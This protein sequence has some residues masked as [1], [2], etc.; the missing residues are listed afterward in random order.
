MSFAEFLIDNDEIMFSA[1]CVLFT[2]QIRRVM[3]VERVAVEEFRTTCFE[4]PGVQ[5]T[6]TLPAIPS[7]S[8]LL[9][10]VTAAGRTF[11]L[12]GLCAFRDYDDATIQVGGLCY[13][14]RPEHSRLLRERNFLVTSD[15]SA[16]E[17]WEKAGLAEDHRLMQ[18]WKKVEQNEILAR[19][20][21]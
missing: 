4:A 21:V 19:L 3:T 10:R 20:S 1:F 7:N 13:Y 14:Y 9:Y 8:E 5:L 18:W 6:V 11:S 2:K 15:S 17:A 16:F 12:A